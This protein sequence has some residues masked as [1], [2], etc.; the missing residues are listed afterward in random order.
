LI[1]NSLGIETKIVTAEEI[2][3]Y[4]LDVITDNIGLKNSKRVASFSEK[5]KIKKGSHAVQEIGLV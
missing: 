5:R 1:K 3:T 4:G 2:I